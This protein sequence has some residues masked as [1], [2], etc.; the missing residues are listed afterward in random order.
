MSYLF[1]FLL[2]KVLFTI[3]IFPYRIIAKNGQI[4]LSWTRCIQW[5]E[6]DLLPLGDL[7]KYSYYSSVFRKIQKEDSIP[8]ISSNIYVICISNSERMSNQNLTPEWWHVHATW[9]SVLLKRFIKCFH[10]MMKSFFFSFWI[11]RL[12]FYFAINLINDVHVAMFYN[13]GE[14]QMLGYLD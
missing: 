9:L 3:Y 11:F 8:K 14:I 6:K 2:K 1:N 4:L 10:L 7:L 5:A 13:L 12:K